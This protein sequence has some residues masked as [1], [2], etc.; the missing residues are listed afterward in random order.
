M[1]TEIWEAT[2]YESFVERSRTKPLVLWCEQRDAS[3]AVV[4]Q[5]FL[6]KSPGHPEILESSLFA[7]LFGNLLAREFGIKTPE[8]A[9]VVLTEPFIKAVQPFLPAEIQL[10]VG[11]GVGCRYIPPLKPLLSDWKIP[12]LLQN[13][14]ASIYAFDLFTANIDRRLGN[15]N[16]ALKNNALLAYDFECCFSFLRA[17]FGPKPWLVSQLGIAQHHIF[18]RE[19][20]ASGADWTPFLEVLQSLDERRLDEIVKDFPV[21]WLANRQRVFDYLLEAADKPKQ[22]LIELEAS[23]GV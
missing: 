21:P 5:R 16:C 19:L 11:F 10:K 15:P 7:E 8:P 3:E 4:A 14:A 9:I 12:V 23:L 22:L 2:E 13:Q 1:N 18:Q 20:K 17:L 6:V